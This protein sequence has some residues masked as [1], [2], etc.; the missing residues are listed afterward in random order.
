M[1]QSLYIFYVKISH[2]WHSGRDLVKQPNNH[3]QTYTNTPT[4]MHADITY[5]RQNTGV[6]FVHQTRGFLGVA[7]VPIQSDLSP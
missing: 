1:I 3:T 6:C 2:I 4:H 7:V 5:T